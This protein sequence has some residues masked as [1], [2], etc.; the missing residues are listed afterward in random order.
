MILDAAPTRLALK[1]RLFR[2]FGD[3]S[4]LKILEA[5]REGPSTVSQVVTTTGLTQPNV[6]N[7][8]ACLRD[9]GLVVARPE[10]RHVVYALSDESVRQVL[11]LGDSLLDDVARGVA[12][13]THDDLST[14]GVR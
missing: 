1:A 13:C 8:L 10:G 5:L 12:G 6:S 3:P 7:H 4:R 2:G 14:D 9:C 11:H